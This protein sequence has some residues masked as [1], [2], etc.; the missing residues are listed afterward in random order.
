[1]GAVIG[2]LLPLAVAVAV[3]PIPII[4]VILMLLTP[5]AGGTS[6]GLLVGWVGGIVVATAIFVLVAGV[7]DRGGGGPSRAES[8]LKLG[9]GVLLVGLAVKEWRA[10]P[11]SDA[12]PAMPKWLSSVDRF[13]PVEAAGLG[14]LLSAVNPKNL[15]VCVAAGATVGSAGLPLGQTVASVAV[16]TV[17][18]ASTVALPVVAYAVG[19]RRMAKPLE[20]LRGWLT[21]H[22]QAVM[23]VLLLVIGVMLI[24]KALAMLV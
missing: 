2:D 3:S 10:Q 23:A 5:R 4:A 11:E 14:A 15:L 20:S 19:R 13:T 16:F 1:M 12:E 24:G 7:A 9:L 6:T 18:A 21:V 8:W 17:I 22:N